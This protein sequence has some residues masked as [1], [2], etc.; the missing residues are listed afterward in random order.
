MDKDVHVAVIAAEEEAPV[1]DGDE[2]G[3]GDGDRAQGPGD[4]ME[5]GEIT[6]RRKYKVE[7]G[8]HKLSCASSLLEHCVVRSE[9]RSEVNFAFFL[10]LKQA[11]YHPHNLQGYHTISK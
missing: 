8:R 4:L 9:W 1:Y 3:E 6:E 5:D 11:R 2:D 7:I 10:F